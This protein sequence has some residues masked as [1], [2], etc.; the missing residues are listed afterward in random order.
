MTDTYADMLATHRAIRRATLLAGA[1]EA[2]DHHGLRRATIAAIADHIGVA[3]VV[4]YRYFGSKDGLIDAVLSDLVETLLAVDS[5][6]AALWPERLPHTLA[7]VEQRRAALRVLMRQ[8][9]HDPRFGVHVDRLHA[10]LAE[11][12]VARIQEALGPP[13]ATMPGD[14]MILARLISGFLLDAYLQWADE[15]DPERQERF[16][17]WLVESVRTMTRGWWGANPLAPL[18]PMA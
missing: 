13:V 5:M 10:V 7:V 8:A 1:A 17:A 14:P 11:R 4:L 15:G 6:P 16:L 12:T 18:R 3:K 9:P 2:L